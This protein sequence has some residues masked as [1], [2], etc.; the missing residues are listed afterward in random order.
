MHT[1]VNLQ[2]WL[3]RS[4]STEMSEDGHLGISS[5]NLIV[6]EDIELQDESEDEV[7]MIDI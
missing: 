5:P 6:D 7:E 4:N 3:L 1:S 2:R